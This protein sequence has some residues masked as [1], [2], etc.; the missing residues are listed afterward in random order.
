MNPSKTST[1]ISEHLNRLIELGFVEKVKLP[2]DE[3]KR[4]L[5]HTFYRLTDPGR[6]FL[7]EHNILVDKEE[8]IEQEYENVDKEPD[9]KAA[10]EAPRP[11]R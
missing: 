2:E 6:E 5:P 7:E 11:I 1:T 3:R 10:E 9:I 8:Q 4:D